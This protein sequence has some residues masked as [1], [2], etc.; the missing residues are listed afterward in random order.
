MRKT[1]RQLLIKK[2]LQDNQ[3]KKQEDFVKVLADQG[4][5]VTQATISRDI[6]EMQLMKVPTEN[7][8]YRYTLPDTVDNDVLRKMEKLFKDSYIRMEE[9]DKLLVVHTIPGSGSALGKLVEKIYA[10]SLFTVMTNDDKLLLI[11]R[12]NEDIAKVRKKLLAALQ[13]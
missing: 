13:D 5:D 4:V 10:D 3:I 2:M 12:T 7:N 11:T 1:D 6:K 9:M 8:S